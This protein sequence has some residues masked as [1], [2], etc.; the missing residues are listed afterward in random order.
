MNNTLNSCDYEV[1]VYI[2]MQLD[3]VFLLFSECVFIL[4]YCMYYKINP[5]ILFKKN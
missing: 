3:D 2:F 1:Y 5:K 4:F